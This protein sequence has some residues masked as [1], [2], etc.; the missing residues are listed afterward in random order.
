M[1]AVSRRSAVVA[2]AALAFGLPR[3]ALGQLN[4]AALGGLLIDIPGWESEAPTTMAM[5]HAGARMAYAARSYERSDTRMMAMLGRSGLETQALGATGGNQGDLSMDA[6]GTAIRLRSVRGFRVFTAY[7]TS[8]RSGM[9]LV[10]LGA[11]GA[12]SSTFVLQFDGVSLDE[13]M[14]YAQRFDW[15]AM[16]R[17]AS[18]R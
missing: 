5:S 16:Q 11:M 2:S 1:R 17:A 14:A 10:Y 15:V 12:D 13:A 18:A 9:V 4:L 3:S 7:D 8:D 6:G